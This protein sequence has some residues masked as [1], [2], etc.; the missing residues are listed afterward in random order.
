MRWNRCKGWI[1]LIKVKRK[2]NTMAMCVS[3]H[4][5]PWFLLTPSLSHPY[6][7]IYYPRAA[8]ETLL[9]L[10]GSLLCMQDPLEI[11]EMTI[12]CLITVHLLGTNEDLGQ[13]SYMDIV[14]MILYCTV[15]QIYLRRPLPLGKI[16]SNLREL[17]TKWKAWHSSSLLFKMFMSTKCS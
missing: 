11:K 8:V 15:L 9:F 1:A 4:A 6:P 13:N 7:N 17:P 2:V 14:L 5:N 16:Y 10:K 3:V 12:Q